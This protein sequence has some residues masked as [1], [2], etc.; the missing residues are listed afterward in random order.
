MLLYIL[1]INEPLATYSMLFTTEGDDERRL[2]LELPIRPKTIEELHFLRYW[3]GQISR[4]HFTSGEF[5]NYQKR[6]RGVPFNAKF[7][8]ELLFPGMHG[9]NEDFPFLFSFG[10]LE[11]GFWDCDN[12]FSV[13]DSQL[14]KMLS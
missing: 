7:V 9:E 10:T 13:D 5:I 4:A 1:A 11:V 12:Y 14:T 6:N 8:H 2:L 3:L